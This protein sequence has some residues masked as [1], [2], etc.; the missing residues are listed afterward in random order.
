MDYC[1]YVIEYFPYKEDENP[2]LAD[3]FY[4]IPKLLTCFFADRRSKCMKEIAILTSDKSS[5]ECIHTSIV[6]AFLHSDG[7]TE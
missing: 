3:R 6:S 5:P 4:A 7:Q 2:R 1:T